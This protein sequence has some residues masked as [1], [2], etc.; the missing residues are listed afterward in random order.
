M[1][2]PVPAT[3]TPEWHAERA[4]GVG[5]SDIAIVAGLSP[6]GRNQFD[7][8]A[9]K[10]G[11][12]EPP[13]A[14]E[15]MEAGRRLEPVVADWYADRTGRKLVRANRIIRH[16]DHHWAFG[17][18]D[19]KVQGERRLVE[20]KVTRSRRWDGAALPGDVECQVQWYMGVTRYP[21]ADV[22]VLIAGLE[23]QIITLTADES[24]FRDLLVIGREF[25]DRVERREPPP[26][27]GSEGAR[28]YLAARYPWHRNEQLLNPTPELDQL[29]VE[30]R[31]AREGEREAEG[32][33]RTAE[34]AIKALLGDAEGVMGAGYRITW[35][36]TAD[37][38]RI[39]WERVASQMRPE[40]PT[41]YDALIEAASQIVPGTR[42]FLA[43]FEGDP[44]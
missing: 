22:A 40:N 29:A 34:N 33:K 23:L 37:G 17:H 30:L 5:G 11:L 39:D 4:L 19:R 12:T 6:Y 13:E 24:Y 42:R 43:K 8:Y 36:R 18:L 2:L 10:V 28:R 1:A 26:V 25:W 20:I 27:D 44:A 38:T 21:V 31:D 41:V 7:L 35:K 32:R 16:P 3:G 14:N 15:Y 9:E